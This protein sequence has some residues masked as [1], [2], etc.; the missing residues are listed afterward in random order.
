MAFVTTTE[1]QVLLQLGASE[2]EDLI[3]AL[4]PIVKQDIVDYCNNDFVN[5]R[6]YVHGSNISFTAI[7]GESAAYIS[8]TDE[9]FT[10]A[11]F[12]DACD[13]L[14]EDSY[15]NDGHKKVA[16]AA[17]GTLTLASGE[18]L[19][20]EDSDRSPTILLVEWPEPLK[21][22]AAKMI[23]F[24]LQKQG[25]KGLKSFGLADYSETYAGE[26]GYPPGLLKELQK[27]RRMEKR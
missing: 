21:L 1:V 20:D 10:D 7:D 3:D 26:G 16:T 23:N 18:T 25:V 24:N 22:I 2:H 9:Q 15:L 19:I 13:I 27:Y 14:I 17:A 11:L 6:V 5:A 12:Y 4:I 8:D